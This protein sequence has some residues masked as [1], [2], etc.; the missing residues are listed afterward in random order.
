MSDYIPITNAEIEPDSDKRTDLY[1]RLKD[2]ALAM[3]EG[4]PGAPRWQ[5]DAFADDSIGLASFGLNVNRNLLLG[6]GALFDTGPAGAVTIK[7]SYNVLAV[8]ALNDYD[9]EIDF[10][11]A[12]QSAVY[13][14]SFCA[15]SFIPN[16]LLT[17][18]S[19]NTQA[20][21]ASKLSYKM[22]CEA[23]DPNQPPAFPNNVS[24]VIP[25]GFT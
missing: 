2:N 6:V 24:V 13:T 22:I 7:N 3:A 15:D 21:T 8:T 4:A 14:P 23:S 12:L 9:Y 19:M 18:A 20:R 11:T 1:Q 5:G 17:G 10:I 16:T 25:R